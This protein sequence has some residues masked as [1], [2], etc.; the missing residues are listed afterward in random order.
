M[1]RSSVRRFFS[2]SFLPKKRPITRPIFLHPSLSLARP[3]VS[4]ATTHTPVLASHPHSHVSRQLALDRGRRPQGQARPDPGRLQRAPGRG[5]EGAHHAAHRRC[6]PHHQVCPR[7]RRKTV[8]LMSHLGRPDGKANP[9]YSLSP[10]VPELEMLLGKKVTMAPDCVGAEVEELVNKAGHGDVILLENLRFHIEEE[11]K[12]VDAD[13]NKIKAD[14]AKV[15]EF[16]AGLTK[17]G[18]VYIST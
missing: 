11:G 3:E 8:I 14:K 4:S 16:R 9:K 1:C 12:G 10:V 17:L 13:G 18:D 5:Q 15:A 7:P 2:P 6:R